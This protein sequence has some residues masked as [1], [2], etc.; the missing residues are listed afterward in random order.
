MKVEVESIHRERHNGTVTIT[1]RVTDQSFN[2]Y[3]VFS[4]P[5]AEGTE[6]RLYV[7]R[8]LSWSI[9]YD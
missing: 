3:G 8:H 1:A 7:G 9:N 2:D 5:L 6:A 4:F